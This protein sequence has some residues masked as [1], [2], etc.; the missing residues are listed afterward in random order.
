M[1]SPTRTQ[2]SFPS[3]GRA[4]QRAPVK[5]PVRTPTQKKYTRSGKSVTSRKKEPTPK[6]LSTPSLS[7]IISGFFSMRNT[8]KDLSDSLQRMEKI[9]DNTYRMFELATSLWGQR[10]GTRGRLP[11]PPLRLIKPNPGPHFSPEREDE[12]PRLNLPPEDGKNDGNPSLARLLDNIDMSQI[13][14]VMQSP[15]VQ[16]MLNSMMQAKTSNHKAKKG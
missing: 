3:K 4:H 5:K 7:T 8:I 13:L 10:P 14:K 15:L 6:K 9:M 12:I 16:Q 11:R 2:S 1:R